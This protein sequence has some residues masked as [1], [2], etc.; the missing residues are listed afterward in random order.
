MLARIKPQV[1]VEHNGR[2][3]VTCPDFMTCCEEWET[4]VVFEGES[5]FTGVSTEELT[6]I[7][8]ENAKADLHKCGAGRGRACCIFLTVGP[9][10]PD[11]ERFSEM[12]FRLIFRKDT[13]TAQAE[14]SEPFP[15]CQKFPAADPVSNG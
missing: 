7:G 4:P 10:G 15:A 1:V 11:C 14:P 8:D 2:R 6:V 13:M 5:A 12:R 3:G 9:K